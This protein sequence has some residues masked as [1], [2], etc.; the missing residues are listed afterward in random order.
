[1][2]IDTKLVCQPCT[3]FNSWTKLMFRSETNHGIPGLV[4]KLYPINMEPLEAITDNEGLV[5]FV[6]IPL[7]GAEFYVTIDS[8]LK[9]VEK[10]P[11]KDIEPDFEPHKNIQVEGIPANRVLHREVTIGDLWDIQPDDKILVEQHPSISKAITHKVGPECLTIFNVKAVRARV[12]VFLHDDNYNLLSGYNGCLMSLFAYASFFTN[13]ESEA[14]TKY[15]V[16]TIYKDGIEVT[17]PLIEK[18]LEV[19]VQEASI[20]GSVVGTLKQWRE[21]KHATKMEDYDLTVPPTLAK[22]TDPKCPTFITEEVPYSKHYKAIPVI[23]Y[24]K[25]TLS[26]DTILNTESSEAILMWNDENIIISIRGTAQLVKDG[27]IDASIIKKDISLDGD[28]N[29]TERPYQAHRGFA[30]YVERIYPLLRFKLEQLL[31]EKQRHLI[32]CGHSLGGAG[33]ALFSLYAN[34]FSNPKSLRTYTYGAPRVFSTDIG[35]FGNEKDLHNYINKLVHFRHVNFEDVVP[36][37]PPQTIGFIHNGQL[38]QLFEYKLPNQGVQQMI[39]LPHIDIDPKCYHLDINNNGI[40]DFCNKEYSDHII[41]ANTGAIDAFGGKY[42]SGKLYAK[43][44][45]NHIADFYMHNYSIEARQKKILYNLEHKLE[46]L[47]RESVFK[48]AKHKVEQA[49]NQ[50]MLNSNF[51]VSFLVDEKVVMS[52]DQV[53]KNTI[54]LIKQSGASDGVIKQS[55]T[56]DIILYGD[57]KVT[58]QV[59]DQLKTWRPLHD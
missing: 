12:P 4:V 50:I 34:N 37:V 46:L 42:H 18:E 24:S 2:P 23:E 5:T 21:N 26:S 52:Q 56:A 41:D 44:L 15:N 43:N 25:R 32:I 35:M 27:L 6:N 31:A 11:S 29:S 30:T 49:A 22:A 57:Q 17:L 47:E 48:I 7:D 9:E 58:T 36:Q 1:M 13:I 39:L 59:K 54:R 3:Q 20:D 38:V 55:M 10:F 28:P 53:L 14:E 8:I 33:A 19:K 16:S 51:F 40:C 45:A